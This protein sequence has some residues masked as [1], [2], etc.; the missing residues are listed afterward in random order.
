MKISS[1]SSVKKLDYFLSRKSVKCFLGDLFVQR[2]YHKLSTFAGFCVYKLYMLYFLVICKHIFL[3][4]KSNLVTYLVLIQ[5]NFLLS[6]D[7]KK[8]PHSM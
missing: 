1:Q 7:M 3:E 5:H 2:A 6:H 8:L 4:T